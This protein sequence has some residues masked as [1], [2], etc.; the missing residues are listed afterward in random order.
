MGFNNAKE[1][2]K[3]ESEWVK[4][5]KQYSEAG[6]SEEKI[7]MMHAFDE[8]TYRSNRRYGEHN[9]QMPVECFGEDDEN[10]TN[11]FKK[12]NSFT[13]AF[14]ESCFEGRYAWVDTIDDPML[15]YKLKQLK[16][17]DLELLTLIVMEGRI[18]SEVAQLL[19]CSQ[20]NI[21]RKMMRIKKYL[22]NF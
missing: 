5:R 11:R 2:R 7:E 18:Q 16:E 22:R 17:S 15:A 9:R 10:R 12:F 19:G 6:F 13:V 4:L 8:D 1:R 21:S 14:D 20:K 3:F